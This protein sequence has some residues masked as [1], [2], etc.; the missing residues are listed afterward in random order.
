MQLLCEHAE[1]G[2][3]YP[4]EVSAYVVAELLSAAEAFSGGPITKAVVSVW[5]PLLLPCALLAG[6]CSLSVARSRFTMHLMHATVV[7]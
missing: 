4:E 2:T 1:E 7:F 3:L 6:A 5:A